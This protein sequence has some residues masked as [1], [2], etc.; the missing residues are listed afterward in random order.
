MPIA[1]LQILRQ[2]YECVK[3]SILAPTSTVCSTPAV[4]HQDCLRAEPRL[5]STPAERDAAVGITAVDGGQ[6][7][8]A[9][10]PPEVLDWRTEQAEGRLL[11][12]GADGEPGP[13]GTGVR[14]AQQ[15]C[16]PQVRGR[17]GHGKLRR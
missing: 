17:R 1:T 2:E 4:I 8:D 7:E 14:V 12:V 13:Q 11:A 15:H 3:V 16:Q 6:A 9:Q 5:R 10:Q